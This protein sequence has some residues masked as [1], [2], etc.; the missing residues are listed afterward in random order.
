M[1]DITYIELFYGFIKLNTQP[2]VGWICD[3]QSEMFLLRLS[4]EDLRCFLLSLSGN[5]L[6]WKV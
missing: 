2:N 1:C 6:L 3:L 5:Y 4:P